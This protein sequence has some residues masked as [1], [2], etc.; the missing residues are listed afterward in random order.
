V[1]TSSHNQEDKRK[2]TDVIKDVENK[3]SKL[4]AEK[5]VINNDNH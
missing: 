4:I 1:N 3:I 5:I 2:I